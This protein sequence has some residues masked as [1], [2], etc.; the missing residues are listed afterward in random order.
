MPEIVIAGEPVAK[1]RPRWNSKTGRT[2]TPQRT[3]EAEERIGW[4]L[5]AAKEFR[6]SSA[7]GRFGVEITI[8]TT[9]KGDLDNYAKL[10]LDAANGVLWADDRQVDD[11]HVVRVRSSPPSTRVR[12]WVL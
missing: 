5:R 9:R 12:W 2:Y 1:A 8:T 3:Q 7:V 11:L 4:E 10:I 6:G